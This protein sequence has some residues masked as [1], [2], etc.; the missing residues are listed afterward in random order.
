MLAPATTVPIDQAQI[1]LQTDVVIL[2]NRAF[3][4]DKAACFPQS[5]TQPAFCR[6]AHACAVS[7]EFHSMP[8]RV[9]T[10]HLVKQ[11]YTFQPS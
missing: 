3:Y 2:S 5:S 7:L 10:M 4:A 1:L 9:L 11:I 6:R 8:L